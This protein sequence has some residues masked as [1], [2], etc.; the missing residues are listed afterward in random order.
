MPRLA[1]LNM[2]LWTQVVSRCELL[3]GLEDEQT[4][5]DFLIAKGGLSLTTAEGIIAG[6]HVT[7]TP[8]EVSALSD[9]LAFPEALFQALMSRRPAEDLLGL[10][11]KGLDAE[12]YDRQLV[13]GTLW[14]GTPS[15][16][17]AA[18]AL[19][20]ISWLL[21]SLDERRPD[22]DILALAYEALCWTVVGPIAV[23]GGGS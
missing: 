20:S 18:R 14:D 12:D 13:E 17:E 10:F 1:Y 8:Q 15:E 2:L 16:E 19:L 4:I 22:E 6:H 23:A 7:L 11:L 5:T 21:A 9:L 3:F